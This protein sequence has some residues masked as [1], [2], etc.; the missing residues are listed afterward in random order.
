MPTSSTEI[1]TVKANGSQPIN[2]GNESAMPNKTANIVW[3]AVML[4]KSRTAKAKG[5]AS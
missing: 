4:A 5:R 3:P 1:A 2:S